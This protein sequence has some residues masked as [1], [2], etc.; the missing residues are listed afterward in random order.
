M[1]TR[2]GP[3]RWC[4]THRMCQAVRRL[5]EAFLQP[6]SYRRRK[7]PE[8]PPPARAEP[9]PQGSLDPKQQQQHAGGRAGSGWPS[10]A[11]LAQAELGADFASKKTFCPSPYLFVPMSLPLAMGVEVR[12][13]LPRLPTIIVSRSLRS[14]L[15]YPQ[16]Q[17]ACVLC[18]IVYSGV[19]HSAQPLSV[20]RCCD[21]CS[22]KVIEQRAQNLLDGIQGI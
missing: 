8:M 19:G 7:R 13:L 15:D 6:G 21:E 11:G 20:G 3:W 10:S 17:G 4:Q 2:T 22:L 5:R 18:S 16:H 9:W 12:A 14:A 1:Q